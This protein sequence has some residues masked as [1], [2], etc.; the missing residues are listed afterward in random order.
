MR[1]WADGWYLA[2]CAF[3]M[4]ALASAP[5]G[6]WAAVYGNPSPQIH[7]KEQAVGVALGEDGIT[8]FGDFGIGKEGV[9]RVLGGTV[10]RGRAD[11]VQ[12]GAGYRHRLD[13][14]ARLGD[15]DVALGAFGE[16]RYGTLDAGGADASFF[17]IDLGAGGTI[18]PVAK[19]YVFAGPV[20]R[21]IHVDVDSGQK[22]GSGSDTDTDL[23]LFLG[24]EYWI[25]PV[26]AGGVELHG[27]LKDE[28]ISVYLEYKF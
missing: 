4:I 18:S 25:K 3:G 9:L 13:I 7:E 28:S 5:R 15:L 17:L 10:E 6:A 21:W 14:N 27:G 12:V 2:L 16:T 11:G 8:F 22:G 24:A 1:H 20:F 26:L 23:G 19:L